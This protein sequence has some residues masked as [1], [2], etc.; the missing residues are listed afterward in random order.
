M[1]T[2]PLSNYSPINGLVSALYFLPMKVQFC[3]HLTS[4]YAAHKALDG[5]YDSL[6]SL[7]DSIVEKLIGYSS[8]KFNKLSFET[9]EN[10]SE[11]MNNEVAQEVVT[12]GARL[13]QWAVEKG[14]SDIENLAQEYSGVGAQLKYLLALK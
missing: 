10:Y 11:T 6:N 1:K 13:E 3:H 4:S 9:L 2:S 14:F 8:Q 12:F 5:A 7:K